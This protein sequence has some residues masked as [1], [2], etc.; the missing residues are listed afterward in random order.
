[1]EL[2]QLL[3]G[4][5]TIGKKVDQT[6]DVLSV[7]YAA[8]Q[9]EKNSLFVAISGLAHDGH[10]FIGRAIERGARFIVHQKDIGVPDGIIAIKV[11]DSRRAL[12]QLAKNYF[13]DPSSRLTLIGITGTSGKTTG[14]TGRRNNF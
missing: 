9:C 3:Q 13:G 5:K 7:C 11:S 2:R 4:I 6:G 8:D 12:G 1:M 10:D 14:T